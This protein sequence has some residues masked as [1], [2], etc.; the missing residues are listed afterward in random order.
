MIDYNSLNEHIGINVHLSYDDAM[1]CTN[2]EL[3]DLL[4][5]H[6]VL[7]FKNWNSLSNAQVIDFA[8]KFG[9]IWGSR[10]YLDHNEA[11]KYDSIGRAYTDY[12]DHSYSRLF[13]GIPWHVDIANEPNKPRYPARILYCVELPSSFNGLSTDVSNMAAAFNNLTTAEQLELEATRFV[14]QSWQKVGTNIKELPAIETHPYTKE[15]FIRLNAVSQ[16]NGWIRE[17]YKILPGGDKKS[18]DSEELKKLVLDT[19]NKYQY[20]HN[21]EVGDLLIFDNWATMHRKGVGAIN[22]GSTG[23]RRFT[24]I[25]I[26]TKIDPEFNYGNTDTK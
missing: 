5:K 7:L 14:Y 13:T 12:S 6:K 15:K 17:W 19:G 23:R 20:V 8:E 1:N 18:L 24:R 10:W 22:E 26:D 2:D 3:R 11:V 21:W 4:F 16:T 9:S 25:S